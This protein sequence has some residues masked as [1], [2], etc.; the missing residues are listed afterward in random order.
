M[1]VVVM[2]YGVSMFSYVLGEIVIMLAEIKGYFFVRLSN[3]E[4]LDR[5]RQVLSRFNCDHQNMELASSI[6]KFF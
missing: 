6:D 2:V 3:E 4:E 1:I 5:F